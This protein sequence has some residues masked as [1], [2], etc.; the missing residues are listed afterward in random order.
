M[1]RRGMAGSGG[2]GEMNGGVEVLESGSERHPDGACA[3]T[4]L[5]RIPVLR[6]RLV[7]MARLK[8]LKE[9][10]DRGQLAAAVAGEPL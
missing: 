7:S 6:S 2:T 5:V 8:R 3:G 10:A 9:K 4:V 1:P